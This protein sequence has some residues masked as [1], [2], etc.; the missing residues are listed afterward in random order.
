VGFGAGGEVSNGATGH[1][2][3][4]ES[5]G[6]SV[7]VAGATSGGST[8]GSRPLV[9]SPCPMDG[10]G[11][12]EYESW[13]GY[14]QD[15]FFKPLQKWRLDVGIDPE[16]QICGTATYVAQGEAPPPPPESAD[17]EYPPGAQASAQGPFPG[18]TYSVIEGARRNG[19]MH[20]RLAATELYTDWC[21]LQPSFPAFGS[22]TCIPE[23]ARYTA[24]ECSYVDQ[25][26]LIEHKLSPMRCETCG[27]F[28][29]CSCDETGC[30]V[31]DARPILF[32]LK[33]SDELTLTGST[34]DSTGIYTI[35]LNRVV[36]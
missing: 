36:R 20:F 9:P 14:S 5:A 34:T 7:A 17:A 22:Y 16:G 30:V 18:A 29:V 15:F 2:G 11:P 12:F 1:G 19:L 13:E 35:T 26:T 10:G 4:I 33:Q 25:L 28:E 31:A 3:T 6:G 24:N 21:R 8:S 32:D 23:D 27:G